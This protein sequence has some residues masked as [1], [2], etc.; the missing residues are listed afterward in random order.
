[1]PIP[2]SNVPNSSKKVDP[3]RR[4]RT[5]ARGGLFVTLALVGFGVD[6]ATKHW[7][8]EQLRFPG[9]SE[10]RI[11]IVG[12]YLVLETSINEGALFGMGQGK[13]MVFATLSCI[14]VVGIIVWLF[15]GQAVNDLLLTTA[16]GSITGGILGNLWDRVGMP[17]LTWPYGPHVGQTVYGVR[18]WIHFQVK[19]VF[20]FPVFN[21]AD[22]LLVVGVAFLMW[23]T[24]RS[25]PTDPLPHE[26]CETPIHPAA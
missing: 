25:G 9:T 24:L 17:N 15:Y 10:E 5:V 8:F 16:L 11:P 3:S 19:D 18:D 1:M 14:A 23:Q 26:A 6:L 21:I 22:S 7:A 4:I 2:V 12:E 13:Q 20:D